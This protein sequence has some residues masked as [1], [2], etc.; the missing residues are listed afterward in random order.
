MERKTFKDTQS[1]EAERKKKEIKELGEMTKR[2]R[3]MRESSLGRAALGLVYAERNNNKDVADFLKH[4]LKQA[5]TE[6]KKIFFESVVA[7]N[8][9]AV[10]F[11]SACYDRAFRD[12]KPCFECFIREASAIGKDYSCVY[13]ML[14]D[15]LK[16]YKLMEPDY[17]PATVFMLDLFSEI[18]IG[19]RPDR[20]MEMIRV[21]DKYVS[22]SE[23]CSYDN[24]ELGYL[25]SSLESVVRDLHPED[26]GCFFDD[27]FFENSFPILSEHLGNGATQATRSCFQYLVETFLENGGDVEY[28]YDMICKR[29]GKN[30]E[31]SR[32]GLYG[33]AVETIERI[34]KELEFGRLLDADNECDGVMKRDA[35]G[36]DR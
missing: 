35:F 7:I 13:D 19:D 34:T 8:C 20:R 36:L 6:N 11:N 25:D 28:L 30:L 26:K 10:F 24:L 23:G 12:I 5:S 33:E 31:D 17:F 9:L 2:E 4:E 29:S 16:P 32:Q 15:Y 18:G 1:E 3:S 27:V 14:P 21:S 22:E